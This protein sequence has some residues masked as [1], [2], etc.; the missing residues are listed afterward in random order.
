MNGYCCIACATTQAADFAGFVCPSCGGNLEVNYDYESIRKEF[1]QDFDY[2]PFLPVSRLDTPFP[3]R[4]GRT[5]LIA[6]TRL[7][8]SAGIGNLYLKDETRNPSASTKDRATAV[9][10]RRARDVGAEIVSVASTGNAG[11]SLACLAAA[12][13]MRAVVFVP[14]SAPIAKLTQALSFGATVLAVRGNYDDAFDLCLK[15]SSEF[16]WFN[17]STGYNPFTR[18]GKKTCA[19]E[20]W[21]DLGRR[22]PDRVLVPTGDGN[23]LSGMWKGWRDLDAVG[24]IDK[25]PKIDCVQSESSAAICQTVRRIRKQG[26]ADPDWSTLVVDDVKATT[27]ADSISVDRPRDG[28]A[29]VKAV[30]QSGGEA[31]TIP[32]KEILAAIPE[33]ASATGVF[34]EPAAAAPWAAVK[35]LLR[36]DK[37]A[38]DEVLV[39]VVSGSGLKDIANARTAVGEPLA[40]DPSIDAVRD[41]LR[42]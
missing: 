34:T 41:A 7:G 18:E 12:L 33:I 40:V 29:A 23:L 35:Q 8:E 24:L 4:V 6:A 19:Y 17:R 39:C 15:A 3:L 20:I 10:L 14:E 31:V 36:D 13:D 30:I 42:E 5:P 38:T 27:V 11:S 25:L 22:V 21:E 28:L 9:A 32:D 16:G 37:I 26:D 1:V 2:S